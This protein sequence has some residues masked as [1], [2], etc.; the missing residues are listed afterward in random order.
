VQVYG[1]IGPLILLSFSGAASQ[2]EAVLDTE[3]DNG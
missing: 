3:V 1:V 2:F